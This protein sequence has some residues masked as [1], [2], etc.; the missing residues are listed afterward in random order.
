MRISRTMKLVLM[1]VVVCA[2]VAMARRADASGAEVLLTD[3]YVSLNGIE[4]NAGS[5]DDPLPSLDAARLRLRQVPGDHTVTVWIQ[6]GVYDVGQAI[7]FTNDDR[8]NVIYRALPGQ[9]P[10]L[11]AGLPI[12]GFGETTI[13]GVTVWAALVPP[14]LLQGG[15]DQVLALYDDEGALP[16]NRYPKTGYLEADR[17][18]LNDAASALRYGSEGE[19]SNVNSFRAFFAGKDLTG[20][21]VNPAAFA[22]PQN[23][24]VRIL[25]LWKDETAYLRGYDPQTG[26]IALSR[27]TSLTIWPGDQYYFENMREGLS[28][29]GSW[30]LDRN[31]G[32][33]LVVPK[34]GWDISALTLRAGVSDRIMTLSGLDNVTFKDVTFTHTGWSVPDEADFP[35]AAYDVEAAVFALNCSYLSFEGCVFRDL[36][37]T[38]LKLYQGVSDSKVAGCLFERV[39]ANGVFVHGVN[40]RRDP[41]RDERIEIT[42]NEIHDYGVNYHNAVGVLL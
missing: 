14:L 9:S 34:P 7:E 16:L 13:D 36:G 5:I 19:L 3:L 8:D 42:D 23:V 2:G 41:R 27:A 26:R 29:P 28:L 39:G 20:S 10:V 11:D 6:G 21:G 32:V 38:A 24:L 18:E 40:M 4:G 35:Q 17:F 22:D 15:D 12:A 30:Y 25:H 1:I 37:G 33:L 31:A